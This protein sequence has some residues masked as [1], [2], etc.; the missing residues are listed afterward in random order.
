MC[1][2]KL[3]REAFDDHKSAP[4]EIIF[5]VTKSV[6]DEE[7]V[8]FKTIQRMSE[9]WRKIDIAREIQLNMVG[10][11]N[12]CVGH[13]VDEAAMRQFLLQVPLDFDVRNE[14]QSNPNNREKKNETMQIECI[15]Q[16]K[17]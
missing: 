11:Y 1:T 9:I 5:T 8:G 6:L 17:I 4:D 7:A 15:F 13:S 10:L 14:S 12:L 2:A 3:P 16:F